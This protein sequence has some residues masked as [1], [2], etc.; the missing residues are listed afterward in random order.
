[1]LRKV[2]VC[3]IPT[4]KVKTRSQRRLFKREYK[5]T[6]T[7]Y[8]NHISRYNLVIFALFAYTH[9]MVAYTCTNDSCVIEVATGLM[10]G[11]TR[12]PA[13]K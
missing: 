2:K 4:K 1:M 12:F 5:L 11:N 13:L 9:I 7:Y 8:C 3:I 6:V 10:Q